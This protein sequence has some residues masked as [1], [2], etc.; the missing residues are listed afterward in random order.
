MKR[1]IFP[2]LFVLSGFIASAQADSAWVGT[3]NPEFDFLYQE[4]FNFSPNSTFGSL[5]PENSTLLQSELNFQPDLIIDFDAFS[6]MKTLSISNG[7]PFLNPFANALSITNQ[8][9]YQL[10]D[11]LTLGGN[12]FVG[13]SIFSPLPDN[14]SLKDMSLRGASMFLEYRVSEKFKIGGGFSISNQSQPFGW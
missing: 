3:V 12:S 4:L 5:A 6:S 2:I 13:N 9:H 14:P 10:S 7:M 11:K 1:L 8:A